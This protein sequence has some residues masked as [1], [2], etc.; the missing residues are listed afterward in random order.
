MLANDQHSTPKCFT[1][2][3]KSSKC[4]LNGYDRN[5]F[6]WNAT[7]GQ[8]LHKLKLPSN[9]D[10]L[11]KFTSESS[12]SEKLKLCLY[13]QEIQTRT[14]EYLK[15]CL[16]A[17]KQTCKCW[18]GQ[19]KTVSTAKD[20]LIMGNVE[21]ENGRLLNAWVNYSRALVFAPEACEEAP[22]AY[23]N[24]AAVYFRLEQFENSIDDIETALSLGFAKYWPVVKLLLSKGEFCTPL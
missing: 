7:L 17:L 18:A 21:F 6:P 13:N 8:I 2:H 4:I 16:G 11:V 22:L 3:F 9:G 12:L 5:V 23:S 14:T 1:G 15:H 24:R 19:K 10:F 20:Y